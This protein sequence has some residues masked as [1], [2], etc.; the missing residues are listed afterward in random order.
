V[1]PAAGAAGAADTSVLLLFS[2]QKPLLQM[3][4]KVRLLLL[5]Q[6]LLKTL[7]QILL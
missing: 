6:M 1:A 4:L 7:P 3:L 5:L 2:L